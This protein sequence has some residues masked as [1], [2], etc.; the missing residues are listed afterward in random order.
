MFL[1]IQEKN[2]VHRFHISNV[3]WSCMLYLAFT[4]GM[5]A[6][7]MLVATTFPL[8][9]EFQLAFILSSTCLVVSLRSCCPRI[10]FWYTWL[11]TFKMWTHIGRRWSS[12]NWKMEIYICFRV[13]RFHSV[14]FR[15]ASHGQ[16]LASRMAIK[17]HQGFDNY[18]ILYC[19]TSR[20]PYVDFLNLL[21]EILWLLVQWIQQLKYGIWI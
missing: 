3:C 21:Q 1:R 12:K 6:N 5:L 11:F 19:C 14:I 17:V 13:M 4:V 8:P 20:P 10:Y 18:T 15:Y 7:M 9:N 2:V 16:T